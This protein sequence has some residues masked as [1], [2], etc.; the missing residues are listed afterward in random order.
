MKK[1]I[2]FEAAYDKRHSDPSKNYGIHG[3]V[4][5]FLLKGPKGATQFVIYTN[6][7]LPHIQEEMRSKTKSLSF[8]TGLEPMG[9]DIGYHSPK[10]LYKGQSMV[11]KTCDAL[12]GKPCYYDGTSL[13]AEEFIPQFLAGGS[14]AVWT[15]LEEEYHNRFAKPE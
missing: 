4:I 7:H 3:V 2:R 12:D 15:M 1:E 8:Y 9:T 10:P 5:R 6:W 14:D 11:S 13:G